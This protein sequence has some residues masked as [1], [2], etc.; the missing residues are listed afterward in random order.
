MLATASYHHSPTMFAGIKIKGLD[1]LENE[2]PGSFSIRPIKGGFVVINDESG[3]C[4]YFFG[5]NGK[6]TIITT[7]GEFTVSM[8]ETFHVSNDEEGILHVN[9]GALQMSLPMADVKTMSIH[10]DLPDWFPEYTDIT[11][12]VSN[13]VDIPSVI[14]FIVDGRLFSIGYNHESLTETNGFVSD[15][16]PIIKMI[17]EGFEQVNL[18]KRFEDLATNKQMMTG[19][20]VSELN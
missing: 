8:A 14:T 19:L 11:Y 2:L 18:I 1:P 13:E 4:T 5:E 9:N 3:Q 20:R 7:D 17:R 15:I 10:L 16:I 6:I 12:A